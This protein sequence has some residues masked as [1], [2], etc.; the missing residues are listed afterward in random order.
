MGGLATDNTRS[1]AFMRMP[2]SVDTDFFR[3]HLNLSVHE[4]GYFPPFVLQAGVS[5]YVV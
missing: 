2:D 1:V 5:Q 4:S 3:R